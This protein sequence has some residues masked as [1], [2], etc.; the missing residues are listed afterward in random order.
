VASKSFRFGIELE[1]YLKPGS[2]STIYN[3]WNEVATEVALAMKQSGLEVSLVEKDYTVWSIVRD[4]SV[5][6][7]RQ[8]NQCQYQ[9]PSYFH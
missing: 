2:E 4:S 3:N 5:A 9:L 8:D 6:D 1:I 7:N